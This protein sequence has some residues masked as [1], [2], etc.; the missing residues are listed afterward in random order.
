MQADL[1]IG[2]GNSASLASSSP[3]GEEDHER[4]SRTRTP[5]SRDAEP[6]PAVESGGR[7]R[8]GNP[9]DDLDV[10]GWEQ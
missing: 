8:R 1:R 9:F 2:G 3:S 6:A 10:P 4:P 7:R 5:R